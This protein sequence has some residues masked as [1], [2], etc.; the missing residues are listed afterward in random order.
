MKNTPK[1]EPVDTGK[2]SEDSADNKKVKLKE[3]FLF[4]LYAESGIEEKNEFTVLRELKKI[5]TKPEET[6]IIMV[7]NSYGGSIY[8]AVKILNMIRSKC[9]S[10]RVVVPQKAK[11]A[12]TLMCLGADQI[13]MG[14][15]SE[16]GPLDKP[17]EHPHLE[18][19]SISA[20]DVINALNYLQD[21][22]RELT[23]NIAIELMEERF[24]LNKRD[25]LE[26]ASTIA[27]G[28]I[29]PIMS[30]EDPRI[31]SQSLRL[32]KISERYGKQ[33]LKKGLAKN[34]NV[35]DKA[36]K[37]L[38][39]LL[40]SIL[41]WDYPVHSYA[42]FKDEAMELFPHG[43]MSSE[44]FEKWDLIWDF[45]LKSRGKDILTLYI[46]KELKGS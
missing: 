45:Y 36:K 43:I 1:K 39:N 35:P 40:I 31:I 2:K 25:A 46:E 28:L 34:W 17:I 33:L 19:V 23:R 14:E 27:L 37:N 3:Y 29:N 15:Q 7:L 30:K 10:L 21:K 9:S 6:S 20:L 32:L 4:M 38:I 16:L 41:I 18:G 8:S 13:I 5:K 22:A 44:K 12:A 11:S 24:W 42:I 26:I